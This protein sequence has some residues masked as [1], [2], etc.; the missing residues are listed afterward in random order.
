VNVVR[1]SRERGFTL[2]EILVA[3]AIMG[4]AVVGVMSGLSAS[5]RNASRITQYDR[6]AIL[7]RMKMDALLVD[8]KT[9]RNQPFGGSYRPI[10]T[11]GIEA[12]WQAR[13]VP[14]ESS[15]QEP[16]Q[17]P[18]PGAVVVDRIELEIWWMDGDTRRKFALEGIRRAQ[19]PAQAALQ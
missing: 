7:A 14:F 15:V 10:E 6:A 2:L 3:T 16:G 1:R 17:A 4:I 18:G 9:P 13:V 8:E 19:I 5:V 11:G 12:G